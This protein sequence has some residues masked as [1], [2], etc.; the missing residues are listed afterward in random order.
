MELVIETLDV[1][2]LA[3][4]RIFGNTVIAE[5]RNVIIYGITVV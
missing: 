4:V 5:F 3:F 1:V 2:N